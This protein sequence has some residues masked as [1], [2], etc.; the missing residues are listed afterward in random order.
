MRGVEAGVLGLRHHMA[1]LEW[2]F[3]KG[4]EEVGGLTYRITITKEG[5]E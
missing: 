4:K 3:R 5:M 2:V 1:Y